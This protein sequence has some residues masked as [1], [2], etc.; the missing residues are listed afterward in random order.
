MGSMLVN[1]KCITCSVEFEAHDWEKR[2]TCSQSC[3]RNRPIKKLTCEQCGNEFPKGRGGKTCS[4]KCG[5]DL[6]KL[7]NPNRAL[8]CEHCGEAMMKRRS[9]TRFCSRRCTML[10]RSSRGGASLPDGERRN[11]GHGYIRIKADGRWQLEHRYVIEQSIGRPLEAH[12]R[13]HH[14]NG[15][16]SDNRLEN[17]ELW[18]VKGKKDPSGVRASDYHC[19]GCQCGK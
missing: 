19:P 16:R 11:S 14:K 6:Q 9:A 10:A 8:K 15:D 4:V 3:W 13:V 12:E 5:R 17:L 1:F 7:N 18:K 2:K